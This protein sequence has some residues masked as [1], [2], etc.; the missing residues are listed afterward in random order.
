MVQSV[1][2]AF[3]VLGC[4]AGGPAGVS[5][6]AELT[7]LPKSTVSR[8]LSTLA[9]LGAVDQVDAGGVYRTGHLITELAA[10]ARPGRS[11]VAVARPYLVGLV[12]A[13]G[14]A[15]GLSILEDGAVHY[16][17]QVDADNPVQVRNWTGERVPPHVVS[18]GLVLLA[19]LSDAEITRH[20]AVPLERFTVNSMVD[21]GALRSRLAEVQL[22]GHAWVF[23]EYAEGIDSVAAPITD[24]TGT[25]VAAVHAHGPSYR[26]PGDDGAD[27]AAAEVMAA[28]VRISE[29][30]GDLSR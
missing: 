16:L 21:P 2:R 4:L 30:L 1:E 27:R 10:W 19:A 9:E 18:S 23:E 7:G 13:L 22:L 24:A 26:F 15:A 5:E 6:I 28:A 12:E 25:V 3:A 11:L 17:D 20:L 29:R 14:E 8:L